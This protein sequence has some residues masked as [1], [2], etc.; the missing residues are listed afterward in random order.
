MTTRRLDF[1][2]R[3]V[4]DG[5]GGPFRALWLACIAVV[6]A[7]FLDLASSYAASAL[8]P[9]WREGNPL[10]SLPLT[11][12]FVLGAGVAMKLE[13]Y[14]FYAPFIWLLYEALR[15]RADR[16]LAALLASLPLWFDA[17]RILAAALEN[18]AFIVWW[19]GWLRHR[20]LDLIMELMHQQGY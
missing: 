20:T 9:V 15:A 19:Y 16:P 7:D 12:K 8:V 4:R 13:G 11:H 18:A 10:A 14:L 5:I 2:W 6:A 3:A 17:W 1:L